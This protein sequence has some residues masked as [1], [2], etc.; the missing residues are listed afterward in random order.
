MPEFNHFVEIEGAFIHMEAIRVVRYHQ[1][2]SQKKSYEIIVG[3]TDGIEEKFDIGK[4]ETNDIP[5]QKVLAIVRK[6]DD[7]QDI[8]NFGSDEE[9]DEMD[10]TEPDSE[11]V[12]PNQG[13]M[14]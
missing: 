14:R 8:M 12:K 3:Y 7:Y 2:N 11:E 6:L 4:H 9:A 13:I 5:R 1:T 10:E